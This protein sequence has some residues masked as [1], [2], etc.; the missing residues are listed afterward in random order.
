MAPEPPTKTSGILIIDKP[1][2]VSSMR[3][4]EMV[5]RGMGGLRTG[6]AGTL[7]PLATGVLI[8]AVGSATRSINMLMD[9]EKKYETTIDLSAT[10][11]TLDSESERVEI[12]RTTPPPNM[13]IIEHALKQFIGSYPQVPPSFS[14][15]QIKGRRAYDIARSGEHVLLAPR[16]VK[17]HELTMLSFAWPIVRLAIR[18]DKGFYVRSLAHDLGVALGGDG[19]CTAIRRTAIGPYT[20][21]RAIELKQ[22][23]LPNPY[24][25]LALPLAAAR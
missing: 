24:Q 7:D 18:C 21:D 13:Q 2:G 16:M 3:A 20:I 14:A 10:T 8:I 23:A 22:E 12:A 11:P 6:H 1:L 25:L 9:L 4:V 19:Y 5:R 15:K 17:V